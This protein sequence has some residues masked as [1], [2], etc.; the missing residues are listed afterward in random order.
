VTAARFTV[1]SALDGGTAPVEGDGKTGDE[2]ADDTS[3][4]SSAPD[5]GR[6]SGEHI[7]AIAVHRVS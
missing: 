2:A 3:Q 6:R 1:L 5:L 7:E 4:Q